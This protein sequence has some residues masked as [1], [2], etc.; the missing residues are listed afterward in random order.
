LKPGRANWSWSR[1]VFLRSLLW[2]RSTSRS[3]S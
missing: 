2:S 1:M 3:M